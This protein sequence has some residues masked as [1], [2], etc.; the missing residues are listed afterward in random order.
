MTRAA[1]RIAWLLVAALPELDDGERSIADVWRD[2]GSL[3]ASLALP[4]PSYEQ[5]RVLVRRERA[6]RA[7]TREIRELALDGLLRARSPHEATDRAW[8][9]IASVRAARERIQDER[10]WR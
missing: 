1:P 2:V 3:A 7:A 4:R 6:V 9:T 10:R 5:T 8:E